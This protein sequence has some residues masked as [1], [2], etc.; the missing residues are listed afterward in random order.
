[1]STLSW[2][3]NFLHPLN[4]ERLSALRERWRDFPAR[5]R[6]SHQAI[7]RYVVG[8]GATHGIHERCNFGCTACYLGV[9]ANRQQPKPFAEVK[10]QLDQLRAFLGPGGNVQITSGEVT[11][12][13]RAELA[14][15]VKYARDLEL[16]PMV[17]THG[18]VLLANP[19]YLDFLVK[20]GGLL[21]VSIHVDITQRGRVGFARPES[22]RQLNQVRD[23]MAELLRGNR[24]RTGTKLKAA[25]TMTVN[26]ANLNQLGDVVAWFLKNLDCFRI[27]SLQPQ[28]ETGRTRKPGAASTERVWQELE[29]AMG[30]RLNPHPFQFGHK[31]CTRFCLFLSLETPG[32]Q[33][34]LEAVRPA[35]AMDSRL[36]TRF[37]AD[38]A[39]IVLNNRSTR[40]IASTLAG[41]LV[42]KPWWLFRL[43]GYALRRGW[44][45]RHHL[46]RVL[47][48]LCRFKLRLRPGAL[49]IHSFMDASEIATDL[50]RERLDA[51][52]FKLPVDGRMVA[53][54]EMNATDYEKIP[55]SFEKQAVGTYL[56]QASAPFSLAATM[57]WSGDDGC[58]NNRRSLE[59]IAFRYHF[60]AETIEQEEAP[61][62]GTNQQFVLENDRCCRDGVV[63]NSD[64][65]NRH[66]VKATDRMN[67]TVS[68]TEEQHAVS[69]G[70]RGGNRVLGGSVPK[71]PAYA[72]VCRHQSPA[73][74]GI[75]RVPDDRGRR[76]RIVIVD[77][78]EAHVAAP[79]PG[80]ASFGPL[81]PAR[82]RVHS[83]S[84]LFRS[85]ASRPDRSVMKIALPLASA[86]VEGLPANSAKSFSQFTFKG[87]LPVKPFLV[88]ME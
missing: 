21:K 46:P 51:C 85:S 27:L 28:A 11:L 43:A 52:V 26:S 25:T 82:A 14:R 47:W 40:E 6:T 32:R 34:L 67:L 7:G 2:V 69:A 36:V 79:R 68:G 76:H 61:L 41:M 73:L 65:V 66:A 18:D 19:D 17:M 75:N 64:T 50:G 53:M 31:Q 8:C 12:L 9:N 63:P 42:R 88:L 4:K 86:G 48:A 60:S 44:Q 81:S 77:Q 87:N 38:F 22:E 1:M 71:G 10:R 58:A 59:L 49:V 72:R 35:N 56:K 45:E 23:R 84:P 3:Q 54:C 33:I 13:P 78:G 24:R 39:G 16:S 37:M 74:T 57:N 83:F 70:E 55:T 20:E 62:S 80:E 30:S 29:K 5:A 15:I